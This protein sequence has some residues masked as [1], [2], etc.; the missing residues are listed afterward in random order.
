[1]ELNHEKR[2]E[3]LSNATSQEAEFPPFQN[4]EEMTDLKQ[5]HERELELVSQNSD[6][7][8]YNIDSKLIIWPERHTGAQKAKEFLDTGGDIAVLEK[9]Y[10]Q[11]ATRILEAID[12]ELSKDKLLDETLAALP[13]GTRLRINPHAPASPFSIAEA[14][15][16]DG[17]GDKTVHFDNSVMA[18][19]K[20][21]KEKAAG[22]ELLVVMSQL[23][24]DANGERTSNIPNSSEDYI[25][26]C[27]SFVEQSGYSEEGGKGLILELG[28]EC[29]MSNI[30]GGLFNT[31]AFPD[32][33]TPEAYADFY[34]ETA[35][36]L[37]KDFPNLKLS[38]SGVAFCDTEFIRKV[39]DRIKDRQAE[40]DIDTKLIDIISFHP[41]RKTVEEASPA[42]NAEGFGSNAGQDFD[43][44]LEEMRQIAEPLNAEVTVGEIS[45]YKKNWGESINENEHSKNAIHGRE[46]GY[47][48]YIWPGEQ[49]VKYEGNNS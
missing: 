34:Y 41:Y 38:V 20:R 29:N 27:R 39:I 48:S 19:I 21:I 25:A 40:G 6:V 16:A 35:V 46:K 23:H 49:I 42:V 43:S 1:M 31:N 26:L 7:L 2:S 32:T 44:Q 14:V 9:Q 3:T 8:G 15:Q 28:N 10:D 22:A 4:P 17:N 45:F 5:I 13:D 30:H 11:P 12:D 24:N 18:Q 37:K 36:R 33:V 47:F